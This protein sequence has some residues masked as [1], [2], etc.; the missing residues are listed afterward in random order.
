MKTPRNLIVLFSLLLAG[1]GTQA[2]TPT[3]THTQPVEHASQ[4]ASTPES[5]TSSTSVDVQINGALRYQ[6]FEGFGGTVTIFEDEGIY[7]RHD[8]SQPVKTTATESQRQGIAELLFQQLG[9]TRAR[10]F[11]INHEPANDNSDLFSFNASAFDWAF[12]DS[13]ANFVELSRPYGLKNW[14]ASFALDTGHQQ[15]WLRRA[16]SNCA[17][18]PAMIDEDVEWILAAALHFRDQGQELPYLTI[19]NEPDLCPPGY[20]IEIADY[21]TILKRLG[22][23][24]Q[25]EGLSTKIVVSDGWIPQNALLYM[26]AALADP[27]ARQYVGA[28]AYHAYADGYDNPDVLLNS[29]AAGQPPHAAVEIRQQISDLAA[30]YNLPVWM[31]EVCYCSRRDLSDF[32]L[33]RGRLNHLDDELIYGNVAAFDAM[34]LFFLKRP[35]I[36][37]EL[38]EINFRPNGELDRYE[39]SIYGYLIGHY[40]R[41]IVPGSIRLDASS[42]DPRVRV[43]AFERPD[44]KVVI[45]AIN[46][47]SSAVTVNVTLAGLSQV[48][49]TLSVLASREGALWESPADISVSNS[50]ITVVLQPLSVITL[51]GK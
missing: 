35:G 40:S 39:I 15:A 27:E 13:L 51:F 21:V 24:M 14:W 25:A 28:L 30:Q 20:K 3:L 42:S 26:Q 17:L 8:P 48:P 38:V 5:H 46:N 49:S 6:A 43:V 12:V 34:N 33:V 23:R 50:G 10:V 11:L 9:V 45:V 22:A 4:V 41:F 2:G 31:T 1:C 19:N 29:S 7:N 32:E 36:D 44:G 47:N 37:D 18:D 16:D